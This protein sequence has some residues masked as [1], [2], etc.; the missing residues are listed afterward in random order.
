V[1]RWSFPI[2]PA[3]DL[4]S[5][6]R[7]L[8]ITGTDPTRRRLPNGGCRKLCWIGDELCRLTIGA[9]DKKVVVE[10]E[11]EET[12]T[13]AEVRALLALDDDP[14]IDLGANDPILRLPKKIRRFRLGRVPWVYE[15][16][17]QTVLHQRVSGSEAGK[18]WKRLCLRYGEK[19]DGLTSSPSPRRVSQLSSAEFAS[20]GIE[21]SRMLPAREAAFRLSSK[22]SLETPLD[23]IGKALRACRGIGVW[24]EQYVRGHFLADSDAV[25]LGDYALPNLVSYFFEG[26][27]KGDDENMLRLLAPYEGDRFR[28]LGWLEWSG[29]GPP[30][31]GPRLPHGTLL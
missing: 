30:R 15:A 1:T 18:N 26:K 7:C 13:E 8:S 6:L 23:E 3:Y 21:R 24:T 22:P 4:R 17:L 2:P 5:S 25:P 10:F 11:G 19:W 12:L 14:N 31:R 20:C 16:A 28:V 27:R 9:N 29:V